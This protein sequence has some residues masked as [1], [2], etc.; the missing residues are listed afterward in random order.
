MLGVGS[1]QT[2]SSCFSCYR[3]ML[4]HTA[5]GNALPFTLS[6]PPWSFSLLLSSSVLHCSLLSSSVC[7]FQPQFSV[8][9][10]LLA[11][12]NLAPQC[13]TFQCPTPSHVLQNAFSIFQIEREI[14]FPMD[15][16]SHE[17]QQ[18]TF[19]SGIP[20]QCLSC[21]ILLREITWLNS[22]SQDFLVME[23]QSMNEHMRAGGLSNVWFWV[24]FLPTAFLHA[25]ASSCPNSCLLQVDSQSSCLHN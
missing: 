17:S 23:T 13:P 16:L 22:V 24:R 11:W 4:P 7:A 25:W 5:T 10:V 2:G 1:F 15:Y 8:H 19:D 9:P 20:L 21:E 18:G 3:R 6:I 12:N 14:L